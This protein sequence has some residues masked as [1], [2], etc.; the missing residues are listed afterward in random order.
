VISTA[1]IK[2][3]A[4]P[5]KGLIT[6]YNTKPQSY[7]LVATTRFTT[8]DGIVFRAMEDFTI[9]TGDEKNPS[10]TIIRVEANEKDEKDQIIG[11]RGNVPV[12]T[13]MRIRNLNESYYLKEIRAESNDTFQ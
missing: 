3:I 11:V 2:H 12:H 7:S 6:I 5:S 13:Q 9:A 10:E 4:N 8:A 1:N